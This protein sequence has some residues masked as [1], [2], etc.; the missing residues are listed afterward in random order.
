MS[1]KIL[2]FESMEAYTFAERNDLW[3]SQMLMANAV[4][5]DRYVVDVE[6]HFASFFVWT[7]G[8]PPSHY[9]TVGMYVFGVWTKQSALVSQFWQVFSRVVKARFPRTYKTVRLYPVTP[10][11]PAAPSFLWLRFA[12]RRR[13]AASWRAPRSV[14]G[15]RDTYICSSI[16]LWI[17]R[18]TSQHSMTA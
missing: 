17:H 11:T 4:G 2:E 14:Y 8:K 13:E 15:Y 10:S 18:P 6:N 7:A 5:F 1:L 16:V 9:C 3:T 12:H